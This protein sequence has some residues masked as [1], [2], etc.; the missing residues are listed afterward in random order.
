MNARTALPVVVLSALL[1]T[2]A[3]PE[4]GAVRTG[5]SKRPNIVYVLADDV[6]YGDVGCNGP[7]GRIP[8]PRLDRLASEGMRFVD[9]HSG[10]AVCTPTRYGVLTGR[11]AWRSRLAR[12]VLDGWS[13]PLI[14]AERPTVASYLAGIGYRTAM[15]GKWHLGWNFSR[16]EGP[17]TAGR[18][19]VDF[20]GPVTGGPDANGFGTYYAHS[21]SLDMAPYV[22]VEDGRV[23]AVPDRVT[24]GAHPG[25]W[26]EGPTGADFEHE[27]VLP[28]FVR[29]AR[30]FIEESAAGDAPF[31]LYLALPAP[32]TPIL[33]TEAFRGRSGLNAYGDFMVQVDHHVGEILDALEE[34]GVADDTLVVFT[35]DNGCAPPARIEELRSMGHD[36]SAGYR[37]HKADICEGGHRVPFIARW[38][39]R[40]EAGS[41]STATVCLTDLF[42]TLAEVS[43]VPLP[44]GAAEDSIGMLPA[45]AGEGAARSSIVHHS[46][47]GSFAIR[48]GCW[49][50][51]LCPGSGGWSAPRPGPAREDASLPLVQLYDL[52][53][54]PGETRNLE[55]E[56]PEVVGALTELLAT[57]VREGRSTPGPP[58]ANDREV[59]FLPRPRD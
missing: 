5:R 10:S 54:D 58:A 53:E 31:F 35:A 21:G 50:L 48:R 44:A 59:V 37:G 16:R 57:Q 39:E 45:L 40:V 55:A 8:T 13:V 7:D 17:E 33:P 42:A 51:I 26:R 23:T 47:N 22:Y 20:D 36:P 25:F 38:P 3:A 49:K 56:R 27:D 18:T 46:I 43:G 11:Y 41:V 19:A 15:I 14:P 6:G 32:H 34:A 52:N 4:G 28:N 30:S 29:R 1:G 9:A 12:G 2:C 24:V